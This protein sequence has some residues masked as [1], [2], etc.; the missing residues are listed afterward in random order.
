VPHG[1]FFHFTEL[2]QLHHARDILRQ[3]DMGR[4]VPP[5]ELDFLSAMFGRPVDPRM[6]RELLMWLEDELRYY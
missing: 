4:P 2:A 6:S 5:Q 1:L 3:L